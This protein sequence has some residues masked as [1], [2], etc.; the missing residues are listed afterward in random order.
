MRSHKDGPV[1]GLPAARCSGMT[2]LELLI[3]TAIFSLVATAAYAAL[4]QGLFI[5]DRLQEQRR[6]WQH[7]E[8]VFN[9]MH[10]D[11]DQ[12]LDLTPRVAG[13]NGFD[14]YAYGNSVVYENMLEFTRSVNTDFHAGPASP[15]LRVGYR[16]D[17]GALYRRT[18]ARLDQPYETGAAD[19]LL[20]EGVSDVRLR[21]LASADLWLT[22]WPPPLGMEAPSSLPSA[23]EM[24]VE[25]EDGGIYRWLFHVG[26]S[27]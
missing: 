21:Y 3:A 14:G 4:S 17:N 13:R 19:N 15:F 8:T 11:L 1:S 18:W 9:L 10:N 5:Q 22:R 23:V 6:F 27:R 24:T 2:L 26:P 12:A 25:L 20:L 16:L 7:F